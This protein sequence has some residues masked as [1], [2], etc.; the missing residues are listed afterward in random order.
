MVKGGFYFTYLDTVTLFPQIKILEALL[1]I[2]DDGQPGILKNK[3]SFFLCSRLI[4]VE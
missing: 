1:R 2:I 4:S 3:E